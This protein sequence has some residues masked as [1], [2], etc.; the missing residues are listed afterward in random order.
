MW[1]SRMLS[2]LAD[3]FWVLAL[4]VIGLFG[5]F[6]ALGAIGATEVA[7][8]SI[9]IAILVVLWLAHAAWDSRHRTGR[10]PAAVRARER[11]GF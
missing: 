6:V 1:G 10:D 9:V 2:T 3:T 8:L 4:A 7:W 11:R 5:F